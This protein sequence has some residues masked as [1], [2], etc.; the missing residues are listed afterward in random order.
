[1]TNIYKNI[2]KIS[3]LITMVLMGFNYVSYEEAP[4]IKKQDDLAASKARGKELYLTYCQSCHLATGEGVSGVFPALK[5][6]FRLES[7]KATVLVIAK[8]E[9]SMPAFQNMLTEQQ[10]AD[11]TNYIRNSWGN[12]GE[13]VSAQAVKSFLQAK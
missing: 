12:E 9:N 1:M 4:N 7:A 11:V 5:G 8:G 13:Y 6:C 10:L 3:L 2:S